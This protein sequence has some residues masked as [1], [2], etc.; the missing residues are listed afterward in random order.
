[1]ILP[2]RFTPRL[3]IAVADV[4]PVAGCDPGALEAFKELTDGAAERALIGKTGTLTYTDD[5]ITALAG[6]LHTSTTE[7]VFCV[8]APRPSR[9]I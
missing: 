3:G 2:M 7:L 5:G 8:A 9:R 6:Y 4:L 1:M